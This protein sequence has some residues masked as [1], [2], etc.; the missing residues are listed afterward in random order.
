[1]TA[2]SAVCKSPKTIVVHIWSVESARQH[3]SCP[4][5]PKR[6]S[7]RGAPD[8]PLFPEGILFFLIGQLILRKIIETVATRCQILWLKCTKFD[9]SWGIAS[10]PAGGAYSALPDP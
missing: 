10:C 8:A 1:M 2:S 4:L 5:Q 9:F 3:Q 6:G 7:E